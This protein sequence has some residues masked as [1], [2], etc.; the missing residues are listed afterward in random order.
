MGWTK[1]TFLNS[2][3]LP[4][5]FYIFCIFGVLRN[6]RNKR[7]IFWTW[8]SSSSEYC[9]HPS[10]CKESDGAPRKDAGR[11]Y[12]IH[13]YAESVSTY[14]YHYLYNKQNFV[15]EQVFALPNLAPR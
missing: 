15:Q 3:V 14:P 13:V 9:V 5:G 7:G 11:C 2:M 4:C 10:A 12:A 1:I 6:K 8:D